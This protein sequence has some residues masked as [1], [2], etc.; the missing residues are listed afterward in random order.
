MNYR[1]KN[2]MVNRKTFK[3]LVARLEKLEAIVF[4]KEKPVAKKKAVSKKKED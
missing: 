3:E 1:V 4:A 2:P